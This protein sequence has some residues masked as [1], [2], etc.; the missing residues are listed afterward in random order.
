MIKLLLRKSLQ[1]LM[2]VL[3]VSVVTFALLGFAGGDALTQLR[4]NPQ[5]SAETIERLRS[6]YG[7]DQ[8]LPIR[9][10]RWLSGAVTGDLGE[11][12]YFRVPVSGLV[13]AR[14]LSTLLLGTAADRKSTRLNSS[15][16]YIS[17]AVFCLKKKKNREG[18]EPTLC[19]FDI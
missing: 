17:Y 13:W 16:G 18:E 8:P 19:L 5:I 6:V 10:F 4:D 7:L 2:M 3:I 14:S 9:Y 12:T 11:S 1:G 15:H